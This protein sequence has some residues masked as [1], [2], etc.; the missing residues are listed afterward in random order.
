MVCVSRAE[1]MGVPVPAGQA[2]GLGAQGGREARMPLRG[3]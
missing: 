1:Q 2:A 3:G